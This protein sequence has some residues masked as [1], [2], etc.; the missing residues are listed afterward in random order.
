MNS[1]YFKK[2]SNSDVQGVPIKMIQLPA[3]TV[4]YWIIFSGTPCSSD[5]TLQH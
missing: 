3:N 1:F 2:L 4:S 5:A